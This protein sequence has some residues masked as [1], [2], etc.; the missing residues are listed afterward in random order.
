ML[1]GRVE[2]GRGWA[3]IVKVEER[4]VRSHKGAVRW[5]RGNEA[6]FQAMMG[7]YKGKV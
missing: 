4:N 1:D 3:G 6:V 7:L 2:S 5:L